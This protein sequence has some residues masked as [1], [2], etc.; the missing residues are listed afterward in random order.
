[1]KPSAEGQ[2]WLGILLHR[3]PTFLGGLLL[4][5]PHLRPPLDLPLL[6]R[7]PAAGWLGV[8]LCA[9]RLLLANVVAPDAGSN[10]A[11]PCASKSATSWSSGALPVRAPS[12]YSGV[13]LMCLGSALAVDRLG[14]WLGLP[15]LFAGFWIKLR[16]EEVLLTRHYPAEYPA[17]MARVKALIPWVL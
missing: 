9:V 15:L 17:Y 16:Q 8:G 2:S 6:P 4:L 12:I 11:A 14:S 3:T 1:M 10:W 5:Y 7:A 13:L